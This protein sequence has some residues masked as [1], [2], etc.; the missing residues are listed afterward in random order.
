MWGLEGGILRVIVLRVELRSNRAAAETYSSYIRAQ[1]IHL[2]SRIC[3][4]VY[5][6]WV[7]IDLQV[8]FIPRM[9][10]HLRCVHDWY[11]ERAWPL[12]YGFLKRR[13]TTAW[14]RA[15]YLSVG[16]IS[17]LMKNGYIYVQY[18]IIKINI[19]IDVKYN[20]KCAWYIYS[21]P[22]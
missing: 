7:W 21:I 10:D 16:W 1:L 22:R 4:I 12:S 18:K 5:L 8:L 20:F 15:N 17:T 9:S 2:T 6:Q 14:T 11:L 13:L 3:Y 19:Y